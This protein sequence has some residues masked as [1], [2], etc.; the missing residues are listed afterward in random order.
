MAAHLELTGVLQF[1][2]SPDVVLQA[3]TPEGERPWVPGWAPEYLHPAS[4]EL[5]AGLTFRT[6]HGGEL[7]L[8]LVSRYEPAAGVIDYIRV[9]PG[10]RMGRVIVRLAPE[11]NGT[12]VAITYSLT[13]LSADGDQRL[14]TFAAEFD[15]MIAGWERTIGTLLARRGDGEGGNRER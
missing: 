10:S 11:A 9:T 13:S 8:W 7:T 4:G 2:A 5:G 1:A 14:R 15:G 12:R 6:T 3:F